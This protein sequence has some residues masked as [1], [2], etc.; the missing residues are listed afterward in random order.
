MRSS[1]LSGLRRGAFSRSGTRRCVD[2]GRGTGALR[3]PRRGRSPEPRLEAPGSP[4]AALPS[5]RPPKARSL[6]RPLDDRGPPPVVPPAKGRRLGR[7]LADRGAAPPPKARA[8]DVP[9][10][11]PSGRGPM[12]RSAPPLPALGRPPLAGRGAR[13]RPTAEGRGAP[14]RPAP[15]GRA[16]PARP[17]DEG[18]AALLRVRDPAAEP[19]A[20]GGEGRR[21]SFESAMCRARY[22]LTRPGANANACAV[23]D[24]EHRSRNAFGIASRLGGP[25]RP[26][27]PDH[28]ITITWLARSRTPRVLRTIPRPLRCELG[29]AEKLA[30]DA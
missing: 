10:V 13:D 26:R 15:D 28:T 6:V 12:R 25:S 14:V 1:I 18:P 30:H 24:S 2:G 11:P 8:P 29:T 4:A 19:P 23:P 22:P 27:E 7:P 21:L 20:R 17:D 16:A 5:E 9:R 3:D